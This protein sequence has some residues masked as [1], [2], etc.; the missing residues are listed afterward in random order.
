[1]IRVATEDDIPRML[2]LGRQLHDES[3]FNV[4]PLNEQRTIDFF[5]MVINGG[6]T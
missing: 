4:Y 1:M 2:E 3:R 5:K 6:S